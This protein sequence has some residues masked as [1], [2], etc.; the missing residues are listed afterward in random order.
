MH[1]ADEGFLVEC[2]IERLP[3]ASP[4]G[5]V[6]AATEFYY[7]RG[8]TDV[9][10]HAADGRVIAIEAKLTDWRTALHQAFRNL[11]FAHQSYVLL[12]LVTALR[13]HQYSAEFVRR[14]V[15]ICCL[16]G[17]KIVLL[18]DSIKAEP[19]EPWLYAEAK[20]HIG[21]KGVLF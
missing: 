2:F 9:V 4:W 7:Q 15:G 12:P 6:Q 14:R 8:R 3:T 20:S 21:A 17:A 13:A 19:I 1:F 10:A 11:C 5:A 18:C 16:E